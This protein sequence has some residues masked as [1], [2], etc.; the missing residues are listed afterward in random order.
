MEIFPYIKGVILFKFKKRYNI[1]KLVS[2]SDTEIFTCRNKESGKHFIYIEA[3]ESDEALFVTPQ[4]DL[5][6]LKIFLFYEMEEGDAD[7]FLSHGLITKLQFQTY[8]QY[9]IKNKEEI[10]IIKNNNSMMRKETRKDSLLKLI[11]DI[12]GEG[13]R[14]QINDKVPEYWELSVEERKIE[15]GTNKPLYWHRVASTCQSLKD[16]DG[17]LENPKRGVWRITEIGKRYLLSEGKS[18]PFV[19][20]STSAIKSNYTHQGRFIEITAKFL[21]DLRS[22]NK[23]SF[24][25]EELHNIY[26]WQGLDYEIDDIGEVLKFL[27]S[28][29]IIEKEGYKYRVSG[30]INIIFEKIEVLLQAFNRVKRGMG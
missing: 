4:N 10:S 11:F 1:M 13:T 6:S 9:I 14:T 5:K 7:R 22:T 23:R 27:S 19:R 26:Q 21:S 12:G 29:N 20:K 25:G 24:S 18:S 28:F 15:Q 30:D 17:Y 16:R 2:T 8:Q 3:T